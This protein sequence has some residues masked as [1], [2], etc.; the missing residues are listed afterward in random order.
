[1]TFFKT[2]ILKFIFF[3]KYGII[4]IGGEI[5]IAVVSIDVQ[6]N[7][8]SDEYDYLIPQELEEYVKIGSRVLVEFGVRKVM[9]FVLD[10]KDTS[11][12]KGRLRNVVQVLDYNSELTKEQVSLAKIMSHSLKTPLSVCLDAMFPVFLKTKYRKFISISNYDECDPHI[13]ALFDSKKKICLT[14]EIIKE[15]PKIKNEID[16]GNIS[17]D[18]DI[19]TYGKKKKIKLYSVNPSCENITKEF[20]GIKKKV[21]E[22][23]KRKEKAT[24][25]E[26]KEYIGCSTYMIKSLE[27]EEILYMTEEDNVTVAN[28]K[29]TELRNL[30]F[31]FDGNQVRQKYHDMSNK[32]FLFYTNDD[33]FALKFYLDICIDN[34]KNKKKTLIV[35]PTL[36]SCYNVFYYLR[37]Y[38]QGYEIINLSSDLG[39]GEYY[40]NY[41]KAK[42]G[43]CDCLVTTKVGIFTPLD[44]IATIIVCDESNYNYISEMTPKYNSIEMLKERAIYHNAKIILASSPLTIENYYEYFLAQYNLLKYIKK[45]NSK[46]TLVNMY[47]EAIHNRD[48]ISRTLEQSIDKALNNKKQVMLILNNKGYS[49]QLKCRKCGSIAICD[50]CHIPLTYYKDKNEYKCKYCGRKL[51]DIKCECGSCDFAMFGFGLEKLKEK[52]ELMFPLS[53]ILMIDSSTLKEYEDYQ[54]VVVRVESGEE[55]IIIGTTNII[56]LSR[57]ADLD[58]IGLISAD[59]ILNYSDYR[60]SYN[61]FSLIYNSLNVSTL[62]NNLVNYDKNINVIIQGYNL[63]H[64]AIK[65]GVTGD[66]NSF[67]NEEIKFRETFK[68]PPFS[69]VNKLIITGDYKDIYYC[70]NYFKKVYSS[71]FKVQDM[72]LGPTYIKLKKG[73]QL[74]IKNNDF[75]KLSNLIEE[76]KKKFKDT[77]VLI[78]FERYPRSL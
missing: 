27:K 38:L 53:R 32:P 2:F 55:N 33:G 24:I 12:F 78:S 13:I 50:K 7:Y 25:E 65:Y 64:Y 57:F 74:I 52:L 34:I 60:A 6:A 16:K 42:K 20:T 61:T 41:I 51:E 76:V 8:L 62:N 75:D 5:M 18:Y 49:N 73:V 66:F 1:M 10:I 37:R 23:L 3:E 71:V 39:N 70:A 30:E 29:K 59:S 58:L 47:D 9:G 54:N 36:I 11:D 77:S 22:F 17:L 68:Y 19:Y 40:E 56:G 35:T 44:D 48:L 67:Y 43:L 46:V 45:N 69:E 15:Y 63:D 28:N 21:I 14:N 4:N 31:D 26:L 72:V